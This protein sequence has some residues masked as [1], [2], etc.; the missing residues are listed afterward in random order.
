MKNYFDFLLAMTEKEIKARYKNAVLGFLWILLNPLFQMLIIGFVFQNFIK[1]PGSDYFLFLFTGLL[2][3]NFFSYSLTK[4]T[5][6]IVFERDLIQ[7]AKFPREAI[8][9]SIVFSN[10]FHLLVSFLLLAIYL[11]FRGNFQ[12][13][14]S[15]LRLV[16]FFSSLFWILS[17]SCGVSL[18]FSS[19][20][21]KYRDVNFFVQALSILWFYATPIIYSL[22][23]LPPNYLSLFKYNPLAYPSEMFRTSLIS[24]TLPPKEIFSTNLLLSILIII[25][26]IIF[27]LKEN[28][29][30][31]DWL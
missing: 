11:I 28:K 13:L 26:G 9:L 30:F 25:L 8:P 29:N 2:P 27:F 19:L 31:S 1:T 21:V 10:F 18:L 22:S 17:F 23:I 24:T 7:K 4:T 20:N 16:Y 15:P 5:P 14:S 3:W 6:S 12:F